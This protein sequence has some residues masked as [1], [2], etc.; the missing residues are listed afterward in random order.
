MQPSLPRFFLHFQTAILA[1]H[2]HIY[3]NSLGSEEVYSSHRNELG[4]VQG[5][6]SRFLDEYPEAGC[7]HSLRPVDSLLC[8][9]GHSSSWDGVHMK[10]SI[11]LALKAPSWDSDNSRE[12]TVICGF[13]P[14]VPFASCLG[15]SW[16]ITDLNK[17]KQNI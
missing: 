5:K 16:L 7:A 1:I 12:D 2:G 6:Y 10:H 13:S 14:F 17:K 8:G 11:G 15:S 9:E 4:T 3:L